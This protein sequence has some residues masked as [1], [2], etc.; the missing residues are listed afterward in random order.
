MSYFTFDRMQNKR[1]CAVVGCQSTGG[2][3]AYAL[4][5]SDLFEELVLL[6]A[7][8]RM[9]EG[10]AADVIASLSPHAKADI[11]AGDFA[12]LE[13]CALI[14]LALGIPALHESAH[15]DLLE[16]NAPPVR[17]ALGS[18]T[19]FLSDATVLVVSDP[20]DLL[21]RM[22]LRYTGLPPSRVLGIGTM[23]LCVRL[24]GLMARYLNTDAQNVQALVVGASDGHAVLLQSKLSVCGMPAR[25]YLM[26]RGRSE[27]I[28]VLRS[29]LDD[30]VYAQDRACDAKGRADFSIA[31]A[32]VRIA[33]AILN[34][35]N[36]LMPLCI[37]ADDYCDLSHACLSLPCLVGAHGA[38][39]VRR[40]IPDPAEAELLRKAAAQ[41]HAQ[42]LACEHLFG[43]K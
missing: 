2:T 7:D 1:K 3:I 26:A 21:T 10:Q 24:A 31:S 38:R 40:I 11:W 12:D 35:R 18:V 43:A 8:K 33:D 32:C 6:D 28:T 9:A 15:A 29:L 22:I 39:V 19:A 41:Q 14:V 34:D 5:Q 27:D 16:L 4:A 17:K 20:C 25:D 30:A 13:D 36:T 42:L 23:P 37:D